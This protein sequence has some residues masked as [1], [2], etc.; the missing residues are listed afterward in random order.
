VQQIDEEA[1]RDALGPGE[2]TRQQAD[3]LDPEPYEGVFEAV[4]HCARV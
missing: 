3:N 1:E 2:R 4:T